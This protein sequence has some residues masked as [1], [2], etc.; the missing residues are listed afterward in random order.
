MSS[1]CGS[2]QEWA[3][4]PPPAAGPACLRLASVSAAPGLAHSA[5][6]ISAGGGVGV[7]VGPG[8]KVLGIMHP[9]PG[10]GQIK[11]DN[12][13][14]ALCSTRESA[15]A[16]AGVG[17]AWGH[18]PAP[19]RAC[20]PRAVS[21]S[22]PCQLTHQVVQSVHEPILACAQNLDQRTCPHPIMNHPATSPSCQRSVFWERL[23]SGLQRTPGNGP[24]FRL[25]PSWAGE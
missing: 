12:K 23:S 20:V 2:V 11:C 5:S 19:G 18:S 24:G 7:W 8:D 13:R 14:P 16:A 1:Q 21:S 22:S 6:G 4:A 9:A 15:R 17:L 25:P 10:H 3:P